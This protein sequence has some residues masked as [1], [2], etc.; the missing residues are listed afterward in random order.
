MSINP[1]KLNPIYSIWKKL[2]TPEFCAFPPFACS[3][4]N[5][6]NQNSHTS[7]LLSRQGPSVQNFSTFGAKLID[8]S[9]SQLVADQLWSIY[10]VRMTVYVRPKFRGTPS[11]KPCC[12]S[13]MRRGTFKRRMTLRSPYFSAWWQPVLL[14]SRLIRSRK[15]SAVFSHSPFLQPIH[16]CPSLP[17]IVIWSL[18]HVAMEFC[19]VTICIA[20]HSSRA[21]RTYSIL[22]ARQYLFVTMEICYV[23]IYMLRL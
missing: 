23:A 2:L 15:L 18:R 7:Q 6:G 1:P 11:T 22:H 16:N 9:V 19:N 5:H 4:G 20:K 12:T 14:T 8:I 17:C 10:D 3:N 21:A 13:D